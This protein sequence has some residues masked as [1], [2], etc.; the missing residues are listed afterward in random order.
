M[1]TQ[2]VGSVQGQREGQARGGETVGSV[3]E[4]ETG[5]EMGGQSLRKHSV[6]EG[7]E[8]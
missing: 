6:C 7:Q 4:S 5:R 8:S 3:M 1:D 2:L